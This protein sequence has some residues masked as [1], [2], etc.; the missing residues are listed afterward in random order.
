[1]HTYDSNKL[2]MTPS[3]ATTT[4]RPATSATTVTPDPATK[5]RNALML[6]NST[7]IGIIHS[8]KQSSDGMERLVEGQR[9]RLL[10]RFQEVVDIFVRNFERTADK[11]KQLLDELE[12]L[13]RKEYEGMRTVGQLDC[14]I[15]KHPGMV[16]FKKNFGALRP[17][18]KRFQGQERCKWEKKVEKLLN[19]IMSVKSSTEWSFAKGKEGEQPC[20][21]NYDVWINIV[22]FEYRDNILST[23]GPKM[24]AKIEEKQYE[25][26]TRI[27]ALHVLVDDYS[28]TLNS[29]NAEPVTRPS[30]ISG[31]I[32]P[33]TAEIKEI[34]T[35]YIGQYVAF[36]T[37][38]TALQHQ[39]SMKIDDFHTINAEALKVYKSFSEYVIKKT[40][41]RSDLDHQLTRAFNDV[42]HTCGGITEVLELSTKNDYT[43]S[44]TFVEDVLLTIQPTN[45]AE[46][47]NELE[48]ANAS[49]AQDLI[50]WEAKYEIFKTRSRNLHNRLKSDFLDK[51]K[52]L[53]SVQIKRTT[54]EKL[55][56]FYQRRKKMYSR[57]NL[58]SK[59]ILNEEKKCMIGELE[60]M[61]RGLEKMAADFDTDS[62]RG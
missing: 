54:C 49:C 50:S 55:M 17:E 29:H 46:S 11:F 7:P 39:T 28:T 45:E 20:W 23:K 48:D 47:R 27:A 59:R 36:K 12:N 30:E 34:K 18:Y 31:K 61:K 38:V 44:D 32:Y 6:T 13:R 51:Q 53:T 8:C 4:P 35:K 60:E 3:T 14:S 1:M 26:K 52:W 40:K 15:P 5:K 43:L 62:R 33:S 57:L 22:D 9:I 21:K 2:L 37:E 58:K 24:H 42:L 56:G 19:E 16:I 41:L 25:V 10:R